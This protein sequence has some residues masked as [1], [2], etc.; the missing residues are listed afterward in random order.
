VQVLISNLPGE[1][2]QSQFRDL[3]TLVT[4]GR[5]DTWSQRVDDV[6]DYSGLANPFS[7]GNR[8]ILA[9]QITLR[10]WDAKSSTT[11]QITMIQDM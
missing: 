1:T 2:V 8:R 7:I 11:R 6:K 5:F 4:S 9:L 3:T 10:V